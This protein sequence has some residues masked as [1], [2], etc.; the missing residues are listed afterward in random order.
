MKKLMCVLILVA[1]LGSMVVMTG[2][3]GS[4]GGIFA[5][6]A[7]A[8]II[9]ASGGSGSAIAFAANE[10]ATLR[11]ASANFSKQA[12]K[13][14]FRITPMNA[15]G[16][17]VGEGTKYTHDQLEVVNTDDLELNITSYD[18]TSYNQYSIEVYADEE[19]ILK[20]INYINTN[21]K[22]GTKNVEIDPKETAKALLYESWNDAD[23]TYQQFEYNLP[24]DETNINK[25]ASEVESV[26]ASI[27]I[28]IAD[29][30]LS[31]IT[32]GATFTTALGEITKIPAYNVAGYVTAAD[33]SGQS[34]CWIYVYSDEG[35]TQR[36]DHAQTTVGN[37]NIVLKDGTYYFKPSK[38]NH[39]YTP[40]S[41]KVE[42]NGA[43]VGGISF[44]AISAT[45]VVAPIDHFAADGHDG[46]ST[47]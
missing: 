8:L 17:K 35:L 14:N 36:V 22:S 24:A 6:L 26:V 21:E 30:S 9:T 19:P 43:D 40:I 11:P 13:I 10:R 1:F 29:A 16:E 42:V 5:G 34:D 15:A 20:S 3:G 39:T 46:S 23:R 45:A 44:K 37:Y 32:E 38:I 33:G 28:D 12:K 27:S 47:R 31:K 25:V 7:I 4:S 2:C 41:T 18:V